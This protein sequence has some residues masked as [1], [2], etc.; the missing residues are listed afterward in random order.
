MSVEHKTGDLRR[1][2]LRDAKRRQRAR[3][4]EAG[5]VKVELKLAQTVAER[6]AVLRR[7]PEFESSL[8]EFL[9]QNV[10]RVQ[11]Y[12]LL[13]DL[14][15]SLHCEFIS[16]RDAFSIYERNWRFVRGAELDARESAFLDQLAA[17]FGDGVTN[18]SG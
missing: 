7:S 12:P 10:V 17:R 8:E 15:W 1:T 14:T 9:A 11:D 16:A 18:V 2:Q 4:R 3:E 13:A 6:L 5:V